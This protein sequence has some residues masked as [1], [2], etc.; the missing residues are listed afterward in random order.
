MNKRLAVGQKGLDLAVDGPLVLT[1]LDQNALQAA[2]PDDRQDDILILV[3][4]ELTAQALGGFPDFVSEVVE[5]GFVQRKGHLF[6]I[7]ISSLVKCLASSASNA[8]LTRRHTAR[9]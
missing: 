3:G 6:A 8:A 5:F 9:A 7:F 4:P 2:D 1:P